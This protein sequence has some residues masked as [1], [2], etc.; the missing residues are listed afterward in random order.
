M[1]VATS[2][3]VDHGKTLLV[4]AL[5]GVETDRLEEEKNRGLTID[6]GFAY[7]HDDEQSVGFIDVPGHIKFISNMLAGVAAIDFG[8]LVIAADDG[9]MPQTLEHLAILDLLGIDRGCI[10]LTKVDRVDGQR[11]SEAKVEIQ[12]LL[13]HTGFEGVEVYPVSSVS[14]AGIKLLKDALWSASQ[15]IQ[16]R[17]NEGNFRLAIDRSFTVK[18]SGNVVTGSVFSGEVSVGDELWLLPHKRRVRVR[19]IHRQNQNSSKGLSGDRCAINITGNIDLELISRGNWL[20]GTPDSPLSSRIDVH[21]K[22]LPGESRP[23]RHWTPIHFHSAASHATG[24]VATLESR[25][26]QPGEEQMVQ[27]VLTE[28][29]NLCFGDRVIIRDQSASRTLGGGTV[30]DPFS[31]NRGRAKPNRIRLLHTMRNPKLTDRIREMLAISPVGLDV[32][33]L[34]ATFNQPLFSPDELGTIDANG[35][36]HSADAMNNMTNTILTVIGQRHKQHP[37][38]HGIT[39]PQLLGQVDLPRTLLK[40]ATEQLVKDRKLFQVGNKIKLADHRVE[41]AGPEK[42]LWQKVEPILRKDP[43]RPPVVHEL[44][45]AVNLPP[46]AVDKLLNNCVKFGL[47][48]KPTKNRFFLPEA[49]DS[50]KQFALDLAGNSAEGKFTVIEYRDKAAI[51][52]NLAIEILEY[53]DHIGFTRR[54]QDYRIIQ[55]RSR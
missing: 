54:L 13:K 49:I 33:Q 24:R 1:I 18:G 37:E 19:A 12:N 41:I 51:G 16:S 44:A 17:S 55:D 34:K 10:A 28:R 6:L 38:D 53:L 39:E 14:G 42:S 40:S 48:M 8:M 4:H 52:R 7:M 22:L 36:L 35:L 15:D 32:E 47:I 11:L 9:P 31:P 45:K 23:L 29:L 43:M 21:L 46:A 27:V 26:M 20:S 25:A 5:T 50:F 2:G 3:H 30:I